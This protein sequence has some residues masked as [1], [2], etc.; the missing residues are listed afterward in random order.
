MKPTRWTVALYMAL[1]FACGGVVGAFV[2]RLYTVSE[3]R[4]NVSQRNPEEFRKRFMADLKARLQMTD[5]QAARLGVIMDE[6]R[7]RV[8][9]ARVT[10]EP[11]LQKIRDDQKQKISELLSPSQQVEWQKIVDERQRK[12]E[13]KKNRQPPPQ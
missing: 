7:M 9:A 3:V 6:T 4:A 5:D 8:R 12:R 11:E 2:F 10:I 1:V 13:G